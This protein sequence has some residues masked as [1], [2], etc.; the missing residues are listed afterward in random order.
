[1]GWYNFTNVSED[2]AAIFR[3]VAALFSEVVMLFALLVCYAEYADSC[4]STFRGILSITSSW[5]KQP[6]TVPKRP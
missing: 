2:G 4:L 1:M 5:V 6:K 3:S